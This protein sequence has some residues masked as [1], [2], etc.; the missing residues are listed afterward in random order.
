MSYLANAE[1]MERYELAEST[2]LSSGLTRV[3]VTTES[4]REA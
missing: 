1:S 4:R 3:G 2:E